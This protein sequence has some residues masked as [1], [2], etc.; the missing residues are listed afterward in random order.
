[1]IFFFLSCTGHEDPAKSDNPHG[2]P[3]YV[4]KKPPSS[5]A[6]TLNVNESAAVFYHPDSAQ[7]RQIKKFSDSMVYDGM[8]HEFFYQMRNARLVI[9]NTWPELKI[10]E[11]K[12]CR[13]LLFTKKNHT[14]ELVDLNSKNDAY[15]L[16]VFNTIKPPLLIDMTNIE[17]EVSFYLK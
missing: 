15:G 9:K 7:L 1:M 12:N 17:T 8:M 11:A 14:H 10:I 16:F 6:D 4:F 2:K 13:Y 3:G 5:Y